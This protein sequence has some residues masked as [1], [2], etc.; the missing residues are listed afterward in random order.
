MKKKKS[1]RMN[2]LFQSIHDK[3]QDGVIDNGKY[4]ERNQSAG[5]KNKDN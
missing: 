3:M 5:Q 4:K 1:G 2:S